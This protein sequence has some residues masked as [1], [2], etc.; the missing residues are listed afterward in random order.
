MDS[1][2]HFYRDRF[3]RYCKGMKDL[4]PHTI[5]GYATDLKF[6]I[7]FLETQDRPVSTYGEIKRHTLEIY[8]DSMHEKYE[9][10]SI[11]RRFACLRSFFSFLE[12]E[13]I[14]TENPFFKFRL[15]LRTPQQ[16][17]RC[18]SPA[19]LER[20]LTAAYGRTPRGKREAIFIT[21]DIA[22]LELLFAAG[23]R[24]GE[25]T[26]LSLS[27]Y[28]PAEC[29]LRIHGKGNKERLLYLAAGSARTA[30]HAWLDNR[31]F[32]EC[33]DPSI[34]LTKFRTPL[35][36]QDVRNIVTKYSGLAGLDKNVTPHFFRHSFA[37]LLLDEGVDIKYIQEFLGHSSIS[38]TQIYLHTSEAK[39]KQ[40]LQSKHP[41][42]QMRPE[43][44]QF[45]MP[46]L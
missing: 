4:S 38:T 45:H 8:L 36:T 21:R 46:G 17:P 18:L 3:L 33:G 40:I 27:D 20:I 10:R 29:S 9:V 14:I 24:V 43:E 23:M 15:Q 44:A 7:Q 42:N 22:V 6:F 25:L 5:R 26:A 31:H 1:E 32:Y 30:L 41:R 11:R 35:S 39:K 2:L 34:F 19:E 37:S 16:L 12:Y 28:D 13:G